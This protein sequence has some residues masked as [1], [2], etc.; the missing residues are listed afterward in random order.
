KRVHM[1]FSEYRVGFLPCPVCVQWWAPICCSASLYESHCRGTFT[2]FFQV[3]WGHAPFPWQR[4][5]A[6]RLVEG[7]WPKLLDL[8]TASGKTAC[9]DAAVYAL[10]WERT[11][12]WPHDG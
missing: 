10:A 6:K 9:M 3:L 1:S 4:L 12:P 2:T 11:A 7:E 5:L 8:P